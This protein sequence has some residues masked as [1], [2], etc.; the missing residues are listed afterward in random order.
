MF[1]PSE[2]EIPKPLT[3]GNSLGL[4]KTPKVK[5]VHSI[6]DPKD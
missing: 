6:G 5:A 2:K 3:R 1:I 4:V